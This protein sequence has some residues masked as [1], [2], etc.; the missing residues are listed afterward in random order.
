[1]TPSKFTKNGGGSD[2]DLDSLRAHRDHAVNM[3]RHHQRLVQ[4]YEFLL[5]DIETR[6]KFLSVGNRKEQNS[7]L[8]KAVLKYGEKP[9][10]INNAGF[11]YGNH[12]RLFKQKRFGG[13]KAKDFDGIVI[14]T[15]AKFVYSVQTDLSSDKVTM[16]NNTYVDL[17]Y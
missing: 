1:M 6:I 3:V 13:R 9:K 11:Q 7:L 2:L 5:G 17:L 15:T 16:R 12:V 8:E 4:D 14:G 10:A